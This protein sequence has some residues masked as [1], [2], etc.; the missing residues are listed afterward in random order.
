MTRVVIKYALA[1]GVVAALAATSTASMAQ[2]PVGPTL[3]PAHGPYGDPYAYGPGPGYGYYY[4]PPTYGIYGGPPSN[5][6]DYEGRNHGAQVR[7][8]SN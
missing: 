5:L 8:P 7:T 2:S 3:P 6:F 4:Y 1:A